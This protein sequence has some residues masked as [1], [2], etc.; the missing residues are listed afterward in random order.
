MSILNAGSWPT[1]V[2]VKCRNEEPFQATIKFRLVPRKGLT[3]VIDCPNCG[4]GYS[5]TP[6]GEWVSD[7]PLVI[8]G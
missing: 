3:P 2:L 4:R 6:D 8:L 1:K 5:L 7:R